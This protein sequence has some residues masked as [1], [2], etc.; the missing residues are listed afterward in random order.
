MLGFMWGPEWYQ[1]IIRSCIEKDPQ[2]VFLFEGHF[3]EFHT[4]FQHR[5]IPKLLEHDPLQSIQ[6]DFFLLDFPSQL[7][8]IHRW[9][10]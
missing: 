3:F 7:R 4:E 10:G 8:H 5:I 6:I 2:M 9:K 1:Q